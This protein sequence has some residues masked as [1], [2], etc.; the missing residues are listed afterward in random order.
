MIQDRFAPPPHPPLA[1]LGRVPGGG[2]TAH[3]VRRAARKGSPGAG[4]PAN[5]RGREAFRLPGG[6]REPCDGRSARR[7]AVPPS[8]PIGEPWGQVVP[9]ALG[10]SPCGAAG[11]KALCLTNAEQPVRP[12]DQ[13]GSEAET[14]SGVRVDGRAGEAQVAG[15]DG[16]EPGALP[17]AGDAAAP[18]EARVDVPE[19]EGAGANGELAKRASESM[20]SGDTPDPGA[21]AERIEDQRVF[22]ALPSL[23]TAGRSTPAPAVPLRSEAADAAKQ[24]AAG[25]VQRLDGASSLAERPAG[26]LAQS[27]DHRFAAAPPSAQRGSEATLEIAD[28]VPNREG[29]RLL[30][31]LRLPELLDFSFSATNDG[32][33]D[34][35]TGWDTPGGGPVAP[36]PERAGAGA[37][38]PGVGAAPAVRLAEMP[39][40]VARTAASTRMGDEVEVRLRL[41]PPSLGQVRLRLTATVDG[42]RV[43]MVTQSREAAALLAESQPRLREEFSRQGL[44]L[45]SFSATLDHGSGFGSGSDGDHRAPPHV[46][47]PSS[48]G[49]DNRWTAGDAES[50]DDPG[51]SWVGGRSSVGA[52]DTRA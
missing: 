27:Q 24:R 20:G 7:A 2:N 14:P 30:E 36:T 34:V 3:G 32:A 33:E 8:P 12:L 31:P 35:Q 48:L 46:P 15:A 41:D 42:V 4:R 11:G 18:V 47:G 40:M 1:S 38:T 21:L 44:S 29:I 9:F 45:H 22:L 23:P 37:P 39:A 6:S 10:G 19:A 52:L 17:E 16:A 26:A 51:S 50:L 5:G 43:Q 28:L 25:S 13:G 49:N